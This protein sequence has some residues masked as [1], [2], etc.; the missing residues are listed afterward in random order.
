MNIE[1]RRGEERRRQV[2][3]EAKEANIPKNWKEKKVIIIQNFVK[4]SCIHFYVEQS[5]L[6]QI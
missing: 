2:S 3:K 6:R 4:Y 5:L 1:K